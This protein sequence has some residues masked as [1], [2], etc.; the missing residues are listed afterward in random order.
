MA[1]RR[2]GLY[3][4]LLDPAINRERSAGAN[5]FSGDVE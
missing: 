3:R 1:D 2:P 4:R 5:L